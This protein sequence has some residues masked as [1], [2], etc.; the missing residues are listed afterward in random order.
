MKYTEQDLTDVIERVNDLTDNNNY[1]VNAEY[2][3]R[4]EIENIKEILY[5][6]VI[7]LKAKGYLPKN[8]NNTMHDHY[9][10]EAWEKESNK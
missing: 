1:L 7:T 5:D 3:Q 6:V 8:A 4:Q 9:I 10:D 2:D